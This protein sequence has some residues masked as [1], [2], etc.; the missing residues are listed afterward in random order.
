MAAGRSGAFKARTLTFLLTFFIAGLGSMEAAYC[1]S[2]ESLRS[3]LP[4]SVGEWK[5]VEGDRFFD[6][7]S[8][9]GYIDGAGE[10]YRAYN[11]RRCL[12]RRYTNAGDSAIVLDIFEMGAPADAYGV[13]THDRDGEPID[14]GQEG[15]YNAGWLRFWKGVFFV[16]ILDEAQTPASKRIAMRVGEMVAERIREAGEKPDLV[17]LLPS[18]G[19]QKRSIRYLHDPTVLN[20]HYYLSEDN[21]LHL[22]AKSEAVLAEY[23]RGVEKALLLVIFYP[24]GEKAKEAHQSVLLHYLPDAGGAGTARLENGKWSSVALFGRYIAFILE[25]NSREFSTK[26]ISETLVRLDARQNPEREERP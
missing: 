23:E 21:I 10:V 7:E 24:S 22:E 3:S 6:H 18:T 11:M 13:F 1:D 4:G 2:L 15:L 8:I 25:A 5:T 9:F 14:L 26:L 20:T 16:S 17:R 12:A 19:L